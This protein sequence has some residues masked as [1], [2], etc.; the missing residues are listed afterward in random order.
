MTELQDSKIKKV[1]QEID[2]LKATRDSK[3]NELEQL[4]EWATA[5]EEEKKQRE[6]KPVTSYIPT[7]QHHPSTTGSSQI[8][9]EPIPL[10]LRHIRDG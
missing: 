8:G 3:K 2:T 9:P 5:G 7:F 10:A 6:N 1:Q 4:R